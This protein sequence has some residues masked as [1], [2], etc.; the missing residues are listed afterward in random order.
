MPRAPTNDQAERE[1][2]I[3]LRTWQAMNP[4]AQALI[5]G[6]RTDAIS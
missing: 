4:G 2:A 3:Y 6:E 5:V 1:I